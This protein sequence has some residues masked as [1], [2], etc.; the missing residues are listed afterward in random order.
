MKKLLLSLFTS[1]IILAPF[2]SRGIA[3][4]NFN[5]VVTTAN[6][7]AFQAN[8]E[9]QKKLTNIE[10][11]YPD[12]S[13][14][15]SRLVFQSN[16]TGSS[17]IYVMNSDGSKVVRLTTHSGN[18]AGPHFSPDGSKI[19]FDSDRDGNSEIY[20][21][22]SDGTGQTRLTTNPADDGHPNWSLDGTRII[23]DS[24]RDTPNPKADWWD[25]Y[26][27]LYSMKVD[28]T[29]LRKITNCR[30]VC[31][32][33]SWSPDGKRIAYRK[34]I[35]TPGFYDDKNL[36]LSTTNSEVFI[37]NSDGSN[38][39]NLS[40]SAAYDAWPSWSPDGTKILFGSNRAGVTQVYV[41]NVDGSHLTR[42]MDDRETD[43]DTRARWSRD[44]SKIAFTRMRKG[45]MDIYVLQVGKSR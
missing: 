8:S 23:F 35:N 27:D 20:I 40:K 11:A 41:V 5:R 38:E 26:H 44:A 3:L 28:G 33:G 37:A 13:P 9:E 24:S 16:R 42:L 15:G 45:T 29:D 14:D 12:W 32:Y 21:M 22:N 4:S 1:V 43:E 39:L 17:Q 34:V 10:N 25:Q 19:T 30:T 7:T 36:T 18:D 2:T 6:S 31:T